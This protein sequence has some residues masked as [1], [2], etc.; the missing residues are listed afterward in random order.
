MTREEINKFL[1][2][3]KVYV[4]GKSKEIQKKLFTL[5]YEWNEGGTNVVFTECPFLY[6]NNKHHISYGCDMHVFIEH[7]HREITAEEIISLELT[8]PSLEEKFDPK[9]LQPFDKV[10]VFNIAGFWSCDYFSNVVDEDYME[11]YVQLPYMCV[12]DNVERVIPFNEETKHLV[13]TNKE[14]PEYYRY[15]E[16]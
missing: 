8:E 6:I 12:G 3:T 16:E 5:G 13:G 1:A 7:K 11:D 2:N 9:V 4:A 14:A 15:W 10:L